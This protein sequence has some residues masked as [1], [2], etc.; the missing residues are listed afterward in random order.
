[1]LHTVTNALLAP[2]LT[3]DN[4][5]TGQIYKSFTEKGRFPPMNRKQNMSR[6]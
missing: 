2:T 5:G 3:H 4:A 1:M 6:S